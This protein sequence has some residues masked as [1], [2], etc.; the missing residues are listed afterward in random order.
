MSV[1]PGARA[2]LAGLRAEAIERLAA[3]TDAVADVR[4]ARSD[5]AGADDEHDPEGATLSD[6][7]SRREGLR[8]EARREIAEIDAALSRVDAGDYGRCER[9]GDPIPAGRLEVRPT[10][11][12]CVRCADLP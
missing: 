2:R 10:A 1:D 9:C 6:E 5:P 11:T 7:W 4:A 8:R 3:R 12:R